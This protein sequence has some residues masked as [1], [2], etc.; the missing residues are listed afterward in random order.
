VCAAKGR[1]LFHL[2]LNNVVGGAAFQAAPIPAGLQ[3]PD[4]M[5]LA[6]GGGNTVTIAGA[7]AIGSFQVTAG[8]LDAGTVV[9]VKGEKTDLVL[10]GEFRSLPIYTISGDTF[11]L[12]LAIYIYDINDQQN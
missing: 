11:L 7:G 4:I 2:D 3:A 6:V 10:V 9:P 8:G 1:G 5:S 12:S